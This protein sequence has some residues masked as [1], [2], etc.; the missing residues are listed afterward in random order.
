MLMRFGFL[1]AIALCCAGIAACRGGTTPGAQPGAPV[2]DA[3]QFD[4]LDRLTTPEAVFPDA[5]QR[6]LY[7][8]Q[9]PVTEN[10]QR[11]YTFQLAGQ[12]GMDAARHFDIVTITWA[13]GGTFVKSRE[14]APSGVGGPGGGFI[15]A[16]AQTEDGVYDI[17]VSRGMLLPSGVAVPPVDV[18][19]TA[20]GLARLY[21]ARRSAK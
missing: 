16:Y 4:W 8:M 14:T 2:A 12:P 10:G 20:A 21:Q 15:D 11:T 7:R 13:R 3:P 1:L 17:R 19:K 18:E 9:P 5:D 6:G